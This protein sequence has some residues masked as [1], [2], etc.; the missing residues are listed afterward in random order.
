MSKNKKKNKDI[1]NRVLKNRIIIINFNYKIILLYQI[2]FFN[3]VVSMCTG[4]FTF[5]LWPSLIITG[6]LLP[7]FFL[8]SIPRHKRQVN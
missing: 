2:L 1:L 6:P 5:Y 8:L 3:N 7:S 4:K